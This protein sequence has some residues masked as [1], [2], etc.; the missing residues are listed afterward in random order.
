MLKCGLRL[1]RSYT[2]IITE[3]PDAASRIASALDTEGKALKK[4]E[5]GVPYYTA[6]RAGNIVVVPALGHLYTVAGK[7]KEWKRLSSF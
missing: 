3:K 4:T 5:N 2:L 7:K 6:K 1:L